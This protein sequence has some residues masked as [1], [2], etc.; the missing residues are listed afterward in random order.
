MDRR[1]PRWVIEGVDD[2]DVADEVLSP[3]LVAPWDSARVLSDPSLTS[4]QRGAYFLARVEWARASGGFAHVMMTVEPVALRMAMEVAPQF[5]LDRFATLLE[6]AIEVVFPAGLPRD[7]EEEEAGWDRFRWGGDGFELGDAFADV[8]RAG[9]EVDILRPLAAYIRSHPEEFFAAPGTAVDDVRGRLALVDMI[10][11]DEADTDRFARA[12]L[13][14]QG[15]YAEAEEAGEIY[16]GDECR[17]R[18]D[19]LAAI[20][21]AP[22]ERPV[23]QPLPAGS[24]VGK[25]WRRA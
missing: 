22:R 11:R 21:S 25:A 9:R 19:R 8:D 2:L 24:R 13:L 18:L 10:L 6:E 5:D 1:V 3:F 4:G 12:E 15:A 23:L 16:L 14:L 7:E 17:A 20:A